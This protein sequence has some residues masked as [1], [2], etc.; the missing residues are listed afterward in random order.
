M[1]RVL[2]MPDWTDA[3]TAARLRAL[4][5]AGGL[6]YWAGDLTAAGRHY[7]AA[8]AVARALGDDAEVAN[9]LYNHY[10]VRRPAANAEEW[11]ELMR[12]EDRSLLD[13]ALAIWTRL[14][15]E[16]GMGKA[17]WGL[18]EHYAYRGQYDEA[19]AEATG[20]I[21]I[22]SRLGDPFWTSWSRF[23]RAF[24]R[25]M[26]HDY[27]AAAT[28]LGPTLREFAAIND[29]SGIALVM[30]ALSTSLLLS[31]RRDDAYRIGGAGRR[32]IAETGSHLATLWPVND[33]P[34]IDPDTTDPELLA[35]LAEGASWTRADAVARAQV[36]ATTVA[37]D[38]PAGS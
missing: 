6:A 16:Q 4:E 22:F 8:I 5:A 30:I 12:D 36:L 3:P 21:E 1:D 38:P 10:F 27:R 2:A 26:R 37:G 23:T 33:V 15:D 24:A 17:M 9:A 7:E 20:A 14:G 31:D 34:M 18:S 19:E 32:L 29:L 35:L 25:T 11:I 28:D 13:E